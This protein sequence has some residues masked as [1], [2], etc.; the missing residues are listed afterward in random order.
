MTQ[1]FKQFVYCGDNSSYNTVTREALR[2]G[3]FM[4]NTGTVVQ[5]AI[6]APPGMK[7]YVNEN[8]NPVIIGYTGYFEIDLS[9]TSGAISEIHFDNGWLGY[10]NNNASAVLII[11]IAY[12]TG[13]DN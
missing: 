7:F 2:T 9:S 13:G 1:H 10:I 4:T 6:Q 11:D 8:N 3:S 5:L 12:I